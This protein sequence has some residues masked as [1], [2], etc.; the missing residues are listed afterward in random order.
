MWVRVK[1]RSDV[2][3]PFALTP[4]FMFSKLPDGR[5]FTPV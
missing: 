5:A 1:A 4:A 3:T 2:P